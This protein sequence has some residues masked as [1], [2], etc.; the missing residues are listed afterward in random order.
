MELAPEVEDS[1]YR[2]VQEGLTN[3][4][5]HAPNA[6]IWV[7][8][9]R[10]ERDLLVD[11]RTVRLPGIRNLR[12]LARGSV[13][14]A[15]ASASMPSAAASTQVPSRKVAGGCERAFP[16]PIR[17]RRPRRDTRHRRRSAPVRMARPAR[18][19]A[20]EALRAYPPAAISTTPPSAT[21][22]PIRCTPCTRSPS[23]SAASI[24]VV[25]G[26]SELATATLD[27]SPIVD[28]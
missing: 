27:S 21:T 6:E 18:K 26:Y 24:T 5:K 15:C 12:R 9:A 23:S 20:G 17:R 10:D 19:A 2:I 4:M 13:S 11:V 14:A 25:T 1:T 16:P 8:L 22:T 3:A 28:A 7:R